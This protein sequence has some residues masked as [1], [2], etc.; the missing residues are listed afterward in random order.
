MSS[1]A[2]NQNDSLENNEAQNENLNIG[3]K[4]KRG[5]S[6]KKSWVWKW[7]ESDETGSI[8]K[9]EVITGQ[10]C[11]KHYRNGSSTGNLITHLASKHQITEEI[12]KQNFV[13]RKKV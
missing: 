12:K 1:S 10:F 9:V 4:K 13:V 2:S 8:C 6:Q 3:E 5:G 7:F 11:N